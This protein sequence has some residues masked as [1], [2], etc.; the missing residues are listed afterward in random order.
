MVELGITASLD[1]AKAAL[2]AVPI[3]GMSSICKSNSYL[4]W[5]K[6]AYRFDTSSKDQVQDRDANDLANLFRIGS[7]L[8][9]NSF[10][11]KFSVLPIKQVMDKTPAETIYSAVSS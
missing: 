10:N 7:I 1:S 11:I 2:S 8:F 5:Q 4:R 3:T 9:T 6:L